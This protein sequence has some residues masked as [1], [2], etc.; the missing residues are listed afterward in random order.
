VQIAGALM[1]AAGV[2]RAMDTRDFAVTT[3]GWVARLALGEPWDMVVFGLSA[4][5]ELLV[6][7]YAERRS[8]K[9]LANT[10]R[11]QHASR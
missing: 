1:F 11:H 5:A 6:P 2:P 3:L 4:V 10:S 8:M 7:I 9:S